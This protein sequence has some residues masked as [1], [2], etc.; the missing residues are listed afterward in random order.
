LVA[1]GTVVRCEL[2]SFAVGLER[3]HFRIA[4]KADMPSDE[5][6]GA[7]GQQRPASA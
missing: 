3:Y 5:S 4:G 7:S 1:V 6:Y 2:F